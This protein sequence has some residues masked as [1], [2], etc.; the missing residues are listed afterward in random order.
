MAANHAVLYQA[1]VSGPGAVLGEP[2]HDLTL[3]SKDQRKVPIRQQMQPS[4]GDHTGK[5]AAMGGR[6][7]EVL[8]AM[9]HPH[10]HPHPG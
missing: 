10:R 8:L 7:A 1:L 6:N 3:A 2:T 9:P 5:P 4:T